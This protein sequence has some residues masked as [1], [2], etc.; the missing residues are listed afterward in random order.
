MMS[1]K[2]FVAL[3]QAMRNAQATYFRSHY[4][5]DLRYARDFERRVDKELRTRAE[6]D[7]PQQRTL[8]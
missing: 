7:R 2:D 5:S 3:V 4:L 8:L 1:D 6:A